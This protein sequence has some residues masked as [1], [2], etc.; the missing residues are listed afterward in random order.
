[1]ELRWKGSWQKD[2]YGTATYF[3]VKTL[4][5]MGVKVEYVPLNTGRSFENRELL[6]RDTVSRDAL[7]VNHSTHEG[8]YEEVRYGVW[9]GMRAP[10]GFVPIFNNSRE[11]WTPTEF[12]KQAF[13]YAGVDRPIKVIPHGVDTELFNPD[14][15]PKYDFE[16]FTFLMLHNWI[17]RK[18]AID[19][20]RV[21]GKEFRN[22][23]VKFL[24]HTSIE[25][26]E[27]IRENIS[28]KYQ[29]DIVVS[30][31]RVPY[32]DLPKIYNSGD[33]FILNSFGEGWGLPL[34]EA[35]AC[36]LPII[37][38]YW[39]GYTEY[40]GDY[41]YYYEISRI[42]PV[43]P[44]NENK[45]VLL[46]QPSEPPHLELRIQARQVYEHPLRAKVEGKR[47]REHLKENYQWK[48]ACKKII[49]EV[50]ELNEG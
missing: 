49:E 40:L 21:L 24:V 9:E 45:G 29:D 1:M 5:E 8:S 25:G 2:G 47:L 30:C 20:L 43:A 27:T 33:A 39:S 15:E 12:C 35:G 23:P 31:E 14:A 38:P 10:D 36:E 3:Y 7:T 17:V 6:T 46:T 4:R 19:T 28:D 18:N 48:D 16:E 32:E 50:E 22:D 13:Y 11:V 37:V 42:A 34:G 41:P 44:E 26:K